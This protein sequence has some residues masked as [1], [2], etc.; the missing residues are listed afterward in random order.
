MSRSTVLRILSRANLKPHK[1][2]MWLHSPDP[3]FRAKVTE[4]CGL[5]LTPPDD[6][7]V[8]CVDEKTGMQALG[9]KHPG[10]PAAPG[11]VARQDYE[12]VRNGTRKLIAV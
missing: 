11:R 7:V 12:Y 1:I 5:Y 3:D 8:V 4:I 10:R 6:A 9:R 2:K